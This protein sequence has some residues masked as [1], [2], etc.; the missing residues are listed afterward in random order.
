MNYSLFN[1]RATDKGFETPDR[2]FIVAHYLDL[3]EDVLNKCSEEESIWKG[4]YEYHY[5]GK[6]YYILNE[7]DA[8]RIVDSYREMLAMQMEPQVTGKPSV[9][10]RD[11]AEAYYHDVFDVF[12][13]VQEV[14]L[15]ID[16]VV[17]PK[18]YIVEC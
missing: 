2:L 15:E 3:Y 18:Y 4:I 12:D 6:T 14:E 5:N 9:F 17:F 7:P 13:T 10:V 16:N 1:Q 11:L 8:C